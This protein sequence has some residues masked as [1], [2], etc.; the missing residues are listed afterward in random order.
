M[1]VCVLFYVA[2]LCS[3]DL[4]V[5]A[6]ER[7]WD[8][9]VSRDRNVKVCSVVYCVVPLINFGVNI[10]KSNVCEA[11]V[12]SVI[13]NVLMKGRPVCLG[14]TV[15]GWCWDLNRPGRD[16]HYNGEVVAGC[17]WALCDV[18]IVVCSKVGEYYV[19]SCSRV[20]CKIC[21][22]VWANVLKCSVVY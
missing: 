10:F 5:V 16:G 19:W 3:D 17:E 20:V 15:A 2:I 4:C 12:Y 8:C 11:C 13:F 21:V 9:A 1:S 22:E 18:C 7:C 6:M 14:K